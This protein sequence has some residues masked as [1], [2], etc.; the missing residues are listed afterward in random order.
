MN[1]KS[2]KDLYFRRQFKTLS[3]IIENWLFQNVTRHEFG[4]VLHLTLTTNIHLIT[5]T[6]E[7]KVPT[8]I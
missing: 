8:V 2:P 4:P 1:S 5:N 6:Y 3:N 7:K